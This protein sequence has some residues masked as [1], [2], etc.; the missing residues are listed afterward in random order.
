M[1]IYI[2]NISCIVAIIY[3]NLFPDSQWEYKTIIYEFANINIIDEV[4]YLKLSH[5]EIEDLIDMT[6]KAIISNGK[7]GILQSNLWKELDI[8]SRDGSRVAIRL[9]KRSLIRREKILQDGRWTYK[10]FAAR[11]PVDIQCIDH[12]PCLT[13]PVEHMCSIDSTYSP[14]NCNLIEDWTLLS[15]DNSNNRVTPEQSLREHDVQRNEIKEREIIIREIKPTTR[16]RGQRI[17]KSKK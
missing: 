12:V 16:R 10:L 7:G 3:N 6:F 5:A 8:T 14:N 2:T 4:N 1:H 17:V 15:F 11:L 13:C 9:E